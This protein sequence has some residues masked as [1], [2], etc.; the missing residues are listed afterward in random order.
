[1]KS[2]MF[3]TLLGLVTLIVVVMGSLATLLWFLEQQFGT[4]WAIAALVLTL[5]ASVLL[6]YAVESVQ[7]EYTERR[8]PGM[9]FGWIVK[10][11]NSEEEP[12]RSHPDKYI[13]WRDI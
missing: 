9:I 6:G 10:R 8:P 13:F 7:L 12:E 11:R 4:V 2:V 3:L 1:M 5:P